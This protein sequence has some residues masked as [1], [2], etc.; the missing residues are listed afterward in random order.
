[1]FHVA[2]RAL[3][4]TLVLQDISDLLLRSLQTH[5]L[6]FDPDLVCFFKKLKKHT[7]PFLSEVNRMLL[8][9]GRFCGYKNLGE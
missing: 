4:I 5:K 8:I 6:P 2:E 3:G 9:V 1:M 7:L